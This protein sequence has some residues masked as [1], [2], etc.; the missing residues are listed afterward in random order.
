[1]GVNYYD[2]LFL[3]EIG[4]ENGD[5]RL[6]FYLGDKLLIRNGTITE[7]ETEK[8]YPFCSDV[9][10]SGWSMVLAAELHRIGELFE[11]CFLMENLNENNECEIWY[12]TVCGT[13]IEEAIAPDNRKLYGLLG[14][15]HIFG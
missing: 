9:P 7:R 6:E 1:L 8:L 13:D 4:Q 14:K 12:L 10:N 11:L 3:M 2:E 5:I 15:T